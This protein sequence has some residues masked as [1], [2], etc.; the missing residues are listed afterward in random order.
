M[1]RAHPRLT[2]LLHAFV[3]GCV[4]TVGF[5]G[6][7]GLF[8]AHVTGNFVLIGASV[9]GSHLGVAAKLLALPMFVAAVASVALFPRRCTR[10]GRDPGPA[11]L[12]AQM[13]LLAAFTTAAITL[14]RFTSGD[15]PAAVVTGLIGVAAMAV[16]NAAS[17]TAFADLSPTTVMTGNVTQVVLDLVTLTRGWDPAIGARAGKMSWA[18]AGF[19]AGALY[20]GLGYRETGFLCLLLPLAALTALLALHRRASSAVS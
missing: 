8:T 17:R 14:G 5:V 19:A 13:V 4:D 3:A 7:F 16:Q 15:Q 12:G 11:L 2:G 18:I 9:A 10:L 6:L 1:S 20:G